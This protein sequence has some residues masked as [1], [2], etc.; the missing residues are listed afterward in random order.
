ME[1]FVKRKHVFFL[2][3]LAWLGGLPAIFAQTTT[4]GAI[5]G[6]FN[7]SD[8]GVANYTIPINVPPGIGGVQPSL[9]INYS[10]QG[11]NGLMG[12]GWSL[13][14]SSA[15]TRTGRNIY[16]DH[17]TQGIALSSDDRFSLDGMRLVTYRRYLWSSRQPV[18]NRGGKL[19]NDQG[20]WKCR[21][22][23]L[24]FTITD[25][26]GWT[27]T[28]GGTADSRLTYNGSVISWSLS[29]VTDLN[30]NEMV[31]QYENLGD[32]P[33]TLSR[34]KYNGN[35]SQGLSFQTSIAF[36]YIYKPDGI[37]AY[38]AGRRIFQNRRLH[39]IHIDQLA[40]NQFN[41]VQ[42]YVFQY[43]DDFYSH[44]IKITQIPADE[45][46]EL[47]STN[48]DYNEAALVSENT[49]YS[50]L[51]INQSLYEY[52][53]GDY[54]GDGRS[55]ILIY[56][57]TNS[58]SQYQLFI[59]NGNGFNLPTIGQLNNSPF[60]DPNMIKNIIPGHQQAQSLIFDYNGD[61]KEDF[62]FVQMYTSESNPITANQQKY[63]IYLST[64]SNLST[65]INIVSNDN[66]Q[67]SSIIAN[68]MPN[69][70]VRS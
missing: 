31:Y 28:Y 7:V 54:N 6:V 62:P 43:E 10:S 5:D 9:S 20:K 12:I 46:T 4:V 56:P 30:G 63:W 16:D 61:G 38:I 48:I 22:G 68:T 49:Q 24:S 36:A 69:E 33:P 1:A 19:Q 57:R 58:N 60:N 14:A 65:P 53:P 37:F 27:Y 55:D 23:P 64:G 70:V 2:S 42:K 29:K 45:E 26:N 18:C 11:G 52:A 21:R 59:N 51:S 67:Y 8:L 17:I 66:P 39:G 35:S 47:P 13:A 44:L 32:E 3:L 34:I 50:G 41:L 15:I 40:N 25:H